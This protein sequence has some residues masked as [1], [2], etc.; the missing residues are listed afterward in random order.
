MLS[1]ANNHIGDGGHRG[2]RTPFECSNGL[3][4]ATVG[5]GGDIAGEA[6]GARAVVE[7]D[8]IRVGFL[9][10]AGVFAFPRLRGAGIGAGASLIRS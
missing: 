6:R 7:R 3:G 1:L 2:L 4:I 5:A 9:A 10:Y 8:G